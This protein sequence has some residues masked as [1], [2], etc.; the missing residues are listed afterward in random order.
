VS[1]QD[2]IS[3]VDDIRLLQRARRGDEAA[4]SGLFARFQRAIYHYAAYMCGRDAADDIVQETFMA[5]LQQTERHDRPQGAVLGYLIG[6]AR[7]RA[8]KRIACRNEPLLVEEFDEHIESTAA[9]DRP[10]PLD[11]LARGE[12]IETVRAAVESLPAV[13]REVIV[14]CELQ[15]MDYAAAAHVAQCPIGTIRSRLHRARTLLAAKLAAT[16]PIVRRE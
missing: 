2:Y 12:T 5:V 6:I 7:H 3:E 10:T 4:F 8:L 13:Y 1:Y 16:K 15:E 9:S 14:L 11:D